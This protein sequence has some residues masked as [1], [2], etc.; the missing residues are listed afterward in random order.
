[1]K[2]LI[3]PE[4]YQ[5][6]MPYLIVK[7]AVDFLLFTQK[8]FGAIERHKHMRTE[9]LIMHAE[10][11]IGDSVIMV[12][13]STDQFP[14]RPAGM[15]I[16]VGDADATFQ[17]ALA[18]GATVVMDMADQPYGRSGGVLDPF[19]NSWWITTNINKKN[20]LPT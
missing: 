8:V 16:Y 18:E 1:M 11:M 10:I 17:K 4:G 6:L 2:K 5:Q 7:G 14:T 20:P 15:F 9:T 19:G 13:D 3:I 12:A